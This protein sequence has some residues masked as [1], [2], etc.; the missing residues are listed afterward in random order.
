M[1][2]LF[3]FGTLTGR[4]NERVSL[5]S[6]DVKD[7]LLKNI[8]IYKQYRH[9]LRQDVYHLIPPSVA[10]D[11]WDAIEFC[12]RNG[13][14]AVILVFRSMSRVTEKSLAVR[15]LMPDIEYRI[16]SANSGET[17]VLLGR[18]IM[19]ALIVKLPEG[20]SSEIHLIKRADRAI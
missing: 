14:E 3:G 18:E 17:V 20:D 8:P 19:K 10:A 16:S 7:A 15:G 13:D 5:F 6:T 11:E 1:I 2:G 12:T 4:L 9:L